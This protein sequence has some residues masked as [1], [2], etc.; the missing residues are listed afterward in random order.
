VNTRDQLNSIRKRIQAHDQPLKEA[1]GRRD[2]VLRAA[3]SFPGALR[4]FASG[5]LRTGFVNHPVGDGD[6]GLVLDRRVFPALGPDGNNELPYEKVD[7]VQAHLLGP[8]RQ[9]YRAVEIEKMK[10]GLLISVHEPVDAEQDPT[11]DLVI[12][13]NRRVDDA[14]WIPNLDR[15]CW[16]ASHPERHVELFTEGEPE[17]RRIRAW[18]TRIAKAWNGQWE[19]DDRAFCSFNLA[20]L[21]REGITAPMPLEAAVTTFFTYSA[22]ALKNGPTQDPAGVSEPI[23]LPLGQRAAV[24]RLAFA[25]A[26]IAE[27]LAHDDDPARV[28]QAIGR[29]FPKLTGERAAWADALSSGNSRVGIGATGAVVLGSGVSPIK[30]TRSYGAR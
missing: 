21:V 22:A 13:L 16:D 28:A 17:L 2:D 15:G 20:A 23:R 1:R 29:V 7:E 11:V 14:L 30:T 12:G 25:A 4:V 27:A 26:G 18:V 8:L 24:E 10:R 3:S 5:S 9:Q 6:G 19:E